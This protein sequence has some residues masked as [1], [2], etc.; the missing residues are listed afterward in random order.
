MALTSASRASAM[1]HLDVRF[2]VRS[3]N[4]YI[5]TFH[6]LH[7]SWRRGKAPPK[8]MFLEYSEDPNLCVVAVLEEYLKRTQSWRSNASKTQLL[9]SYVKPHV[10]VQSST[11]SRWLKEI[12][13][14]AGIDIK[15]FR[16]HSTRSA[17]SSKAGLAGISTDEILKRGSWSNESTWQKFYNKEILSKEAVFQQGVLKHT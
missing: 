7:K 15:I 9:L 4:A 8:L 3:H 2:M 1:H 6:K 10:E 14:E 17:S 12:L 13:K 11:I 5:F 16:G